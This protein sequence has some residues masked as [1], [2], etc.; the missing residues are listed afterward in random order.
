MSKPGIAPVR[1]RKPRVQKVTARSASHHLAGAEQS[2]PV[3]QF[4]RRAFLERPKHNPFS[5]SGLLLTGLHTDF[6]DALGLVDNAAPF[7]AND[8]LVGFTA[9]NI[10]DGSEG[11][12]T[13][14]TSN[15]LSAPLVGGVE[16]LWDIGDVYEIIEIDNG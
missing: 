13:A 15:N 11:I 16:N 8:S 9:R 4:S 7:G 5:Q 3:Y 12:V 6:D 14:N 10:T 2:Y 1:G